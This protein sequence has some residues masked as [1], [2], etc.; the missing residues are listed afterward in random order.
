[1]MRISL[2]TARRLA[3]GSQG[4]DG[5]WK[6]P[7]GK[8]G[9]AQTVE[10]IGYVQIDTISVVER[11]HHHTLWTRRPDYDP[12]MLHELQ[13]EDRRVFEYWARAAAYVPM[14][15]YR[16]Y[17]RRMRAYAESGRTWNW[18]DQN[19]EFAKSVLDRIRAEGPLASADFKAP[20]EKRRAAWW[21]WKPAK[22][23]LEVLF[24]T[25]ELMVTERRNFQRIYDLTERVLPGGTDTT[26]PDADE[27][28]RFVV[29][30]ELEGRGITT[31]RE[32]RWRITPPKDIEKAVRALVDSR[33]I[34]P[35]EVEGLDGEQHYALTE[36]L[37]KASRQ[38]RSSTHLHLLSP[39]DNLV[40]HRTWLE[41]F[42]GFDYSLECYNPPAKRKYGYFCLPVLW[43]D[44]FVG[45]LD[46]KADRK[47]RAFIVRK[48][49]FEPD[50]KDYDALMPALSEKLRA[51]AAFNGC[52]GIVVEKTEPAKAQRPLVRALD[53]GS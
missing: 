36:R 38:R 31:A 33:E 50:Q 1:M 44:R 45:R 19:S 12:G 32:V 30:R 46:P 14:G 16:Y 37:E 41:R 9:I 22:V 24:A 13:A 3:I 35:V 20:H 8:E 15:D 25:G 49:V 48:L 18:L 51:F 5:R 4:L 10:R 7:R 23:A 21:D 42:F 52:E 17:V 29:R 47:Q 2:S 6:L 28:A 26:E 27:Q 43:G 11:A 53:S 34:T 39:F 40:I